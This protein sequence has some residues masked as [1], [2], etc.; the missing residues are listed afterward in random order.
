MVGDLSPAT[1]WATKLDWVQAVVGLLEVI[2]YGVDLMDE[3]LDADGKGFKLNPHVG[4]TIRS[5]PW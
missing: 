4:P 5:S 3:V 1:S 2:A